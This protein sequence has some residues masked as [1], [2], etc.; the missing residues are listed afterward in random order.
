MQWYDKEV[1]SLVGH[2]TF[3]DVFFFCI[4]AFLFNIQLQE[5]LRQKLHALH[6]Y[7]HCS[8]DLA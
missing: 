8:V 1:G 2:I 6:D 7:Y 4:V 3:Q 5:F